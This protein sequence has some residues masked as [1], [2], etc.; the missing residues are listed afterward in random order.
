MNCIACKNEKYSLVFDNHNENWTYENVKYNFEQ[1]SNCKLIR[2]T[3]IPN[4]D[5]L[6]R[7]Y[8]SFY[9]YNMF[10]W[11]SPF[12]KIQAKHRLFKIS[13]YFQSKIKHLDFGCGHGYLVKTAANRGINSWGFDIGV[14]KI[15]QND[16]HSLVYGKTL[17]ALKESSFNLITTYHVLEHMTN[18]EITLKSLYQ[19][20]APEGVLVVAVPNSDSLGFKICKEKWGWCQQPFIHIHHYNAENLS[21]IMKNV[22]F[23]ILETKTYDTWD[24][25]IYDILMQQIF[26]RKKPR[27]TVKIN[28]NQKINFILI[29]DSLLRLFFTPVS[30]IFSSLFYRKFGAE[31]MVIGRKL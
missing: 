23:E 27:G 18:P 19:K 11:Q 31:L 17:E 13:K 25:N 3:P 12:K 26:F 9:D 21:L 28:Y 1:C 6:G 30:Y 4:L 24:G 5:T 22:G 29:I 2:A 14:D 15:V 8:D 16:S 7:M 10:N 20:L